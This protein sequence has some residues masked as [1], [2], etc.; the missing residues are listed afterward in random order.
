MFSSL[1]N[2]T[3]DI[4][5]CKIEVSLTYLSPKGTLVP[6]ETGEAQFVSKAEAYISS[7]A[8]S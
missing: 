5:F 6:F 3:L 8:C 1:D 2:S 7:Y 4:F